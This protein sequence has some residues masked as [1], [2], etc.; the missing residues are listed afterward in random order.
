MGAAKEQN[1]KDVLLSC[2]RLVGPGGF[3]SAATPR[4]YSAGESC[5]RGVRRWQEVLRGQGLG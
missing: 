2:G 1:L 5:R 4:R 3:T